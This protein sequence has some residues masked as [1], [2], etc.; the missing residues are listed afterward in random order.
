LRNEI[1]FN[2]SFEEVFLNKL[3]VLDGIS[4]KVDVEPRSW[5]IARR[6]LTRCSDDSTALSRD[7]TTGVVVPDLPGF[8][9]LWDG[10]DR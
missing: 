1:R 10:V 6:K 3:E 2:H 8:K 4:L 9:A 5:I 7:A